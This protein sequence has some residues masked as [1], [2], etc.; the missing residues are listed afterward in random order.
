MNNKNILNR[1]RVI[2]KNQ[3]G[4]VGL[5]MEIKPK[6]LLIG[7]GVVNL[8]LCI[9]SVAMIGGLM[10]FLIS[11]KKEGVMQQLASAGQTTAQFGGEYIIDGIK[12]LLQTG[13]AEIKHYKLVVVGFMGILCIL[14]TYM[15][16]TT[17]LNLHT[18]IK[19]KVAPD[20]P[21]K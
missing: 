15:F 16:I 21:K 13:G 20:A 4:G 18:G 14:S 1:Q 9:L 11:S 2:K 5:N 6:G 12:S 8:L 3:D 10:F 17:V 7:T 19:L